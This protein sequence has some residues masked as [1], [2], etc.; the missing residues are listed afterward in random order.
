MSWWN[1]AR[2]TRASQDLTQQTIASLAIP[3]RGRGRG[4]RSPSP[5]A[6]VGGAAFFP[7]TVEHRDAPPDTSIIMGDINVQELQR[8]AQTAADA[9]ASASAA[10]AAMTQQLRDTQLDNSRLRAI[11]KPDLPTFDH[12]NIEIWIRRV[13]SAFTRAGVDKTKDKFAFLE[14]KL[15]VD[16]DPK[17]N[18]FLFGPID[19]DTWSTFTAYLIK[20]FGKTR[21]QRTAIMIDGIQRDGRRPSEML[22]LFNDMTQGVTLDD[23]RKEHLLKQL[24]V[25]VRRALAKESDTL[26]PEQLAETA[27][28][29]FD[30][31]GRP[32]FNTPA[33][34]LNA[35]DSYGDNTGPS[36]TTAAEHASLTTEVNETVNAVRQQPSRFSNKPPSATSRPPPRPSNSNRQNQRSGPSQR[37]QTFDSD[38]NCYYHAQFGT[39]ADRCFPGCKHPHAGRYGENNNRQGNDRGGQRK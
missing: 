6:R 8:I 24:P 2:E 5:A 27:D 7:E 28:A 14:A 18:S 31:Q 11:K 32:K 20:K 29:Y 36:E 33:S 34:I 22:A 37:A 16:L 9:A 1:S 38:G 15:S 30:Q 17:I 12:K 35:V 19:E 3:A 23:I 4:S 25:D 13:E 10:L 21:Q 26:T 39:K